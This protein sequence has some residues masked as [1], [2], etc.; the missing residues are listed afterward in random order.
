MRFRHRSVR[1]LK[2]WK[3]GPMTAGFVRWRTARTLSLCPPPLSYAPIPVG[4]SSRHVPPTLP[5]FLGPEF[6]AP[7]NYQANGGTHNAR[8]AR[9]RTGIR[10]DKYN[11]TNGV[12][13]SSTLPMCRTGVRFPVSA[14]FLIFIFGQWTLPR[15]N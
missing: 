6:A 10:V 8:P 12:V 15:S 1:Q 5:S 2:N 4:P 14:V 11:R 7:G 13:V 9:A 3:I